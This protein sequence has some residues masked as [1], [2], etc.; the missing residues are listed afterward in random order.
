MSHYNYQNE[1]CTIT[2]FDQQKPFSSFLPGIAGLRGI[3]IWAFYA[4]RGQAITCFGVENKDKAILEFQPANLGYQYTHI[5]G[6]RT[7]IKVDNHVYEAFSPETIH[8][9]V[10]RDM[11]VK[12]NEI[13]ITERNER[14]QLAVSVTYY[15]LPEETFGALVREVKIQNLATE[16]RD[17]ELIDGLAVLLP[18]G[19]ANEEYKQMANLMKSWMDVFDL[20]TSMPLYRMRAATSDEA[21][22]KAHNIHAGNFF[23]SVSDGQL[24]PAI[25]DPK[26]IFDFDTTLSVAQGFV[27]HS[28]KTL[29]QQPQ[30]TVN[31]VPSGFTAIS[32]NLAGAAAQT[33][34]TMIG[35]TEDIVSL[36]QRKS[37]FLE[38]DYFSKKRACGNEIIDTLVS[39]VE[40]H[41]AYQLFDTYAKQNF[42]DNALRGGVPIVF[43]EGNDA[44]VYHVYSRKHGD[45]ERDYNFF[46]IAPEYYSQG[47]GN[48]RDINQNRRS[49]ILFNPAVATYNIE[50]FF[51]LIQLDGYNPLHVKGARFTLKKDVDIRQ[52]I[53][54]YF[55][56]YDKALH[57]LLSAPF[58]PGMIINFIAHRGITLLDDEYVVLSRILEQ[59]DVQFEAAHGEGFW[60]DHWTYNFDLV[61]NYCAVYPESV[62]TLLFEEE[63][64]LF[65]ENTATVFPRKE[66]YVRTKNNEV[67]Q[68]GSV[69]TYDEEKISRLQLERDGTNWVRKH[70]GAG[71]FYRTTLAEKMI[72][73]AVMKFLNLD[74]LGIG[75]EMEADKPGWNDAMNGLPGIFGSGLS[76][77]IELVRIIQF[78][79]NQ[80]ENSPY[81]TID[82]LQENKHLWME[83]VK[84]CVQPNGT[85]MYRWNHFNQLKEDYRALVR[86]GVL[87]VKKSVQVS[88]IHQ[89]LG[90]MLETLKQGLEDGK[91]LGD[92]VL[93]TF[94][95]FE[96]EQYHDIKDENGAPVYTHYGLTAVE[97][98][99]FSV[100][101][102]PHFLEAPARYLKICSNEEA[103]KMYHKI[104]VSDMY[105]T[106]LQMYKTSGSLDAQSF[107]IGRARAFTPGWL[108]REAVFLHMTYKYL[109]GLLKAGLYEQYYTEMKTNFVCF[110]DSNEYGRSVFENVSFLASSVNPDPSVRGQGFVSRLTGATSEFLSMWNIMMVG[111]KWFEYD[112]DTL[113]FTF[114]P[115]LSADFF[116]ADTVQFNLFNTTKVTYVNPTQ[117][118]TFDENV[119][120]D[121]I[122]ID[123]KKIQDGVLR[124]IDAEKLRD[125][126]VKQV[127]IYFTTI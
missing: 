99:S 44:K 110:R 82:V 10:H 90:Y 75:I 101:P 86:L 73:L 81:Q 30:A 14:E 115:I 76:E 96:V 70:N 45:P 100:K 72:H 51:N 41:T 114:A 83:L 109:L 22:V 37:D 33:L 60:V 42:L 23:V 9:D 26:V 2:N 93:P 67:R 58:T 36:R 12:R 5:N 38:K 84:Y 77:S 48:F 68:Y 18:S 59:S 50:N 113:T 52:C 15:A 28:V 46:N 80:L 119:V 62:K 7:F 64:Y 71:D 43:G 54:Q 79:Q 61:E 55:S 102:L 65:Y 53:E 34:T 121:F 91:A 56:V 78:L 74:P 98:T 63:K 97:I 4:N 66:K 40:T 16:S 92:G 69:N 25:V 29:I 104:K 116:D 117:K 123:G 122:C 11:E 49:D 8:E 106:Q 13:T 1:A 89:L 3:P 31:K 47:N 120:I 39:P 112:K 95:T 32:I 87:G 127:E 21:E 19:V 108:E 6:F 88:K 27:K 17:I 125:K 105:D 107:E 24:L 103:K 126:K 20:E 124:G 57:T 111:K 94:L 118:A 85:A 35:Y